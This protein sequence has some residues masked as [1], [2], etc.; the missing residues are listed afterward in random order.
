MARV[1]HHQN[2]AMAL[3]TTCSIEGM[4]NKRTILSAPQPEWEGCSPQPRL[5]LPSGSF[6][7]HG[8]APSQLHCSALSSYFVKGLPGGWVLLGGVEK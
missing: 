5:R 7:P 4:I 1:P 2:S 8:T 3:A 6:P